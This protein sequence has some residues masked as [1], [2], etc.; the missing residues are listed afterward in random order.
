MQPFYRDLEIRVGPSY[1]GKLL[2]HKMS[3]VDDED[4]LDIGREE[5]LTVRRN[6]HFVLRERALW[7]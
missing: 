4:R 2:G 3:A 5:I 6:D 1:S 7:T